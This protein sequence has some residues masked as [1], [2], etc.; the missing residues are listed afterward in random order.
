MFKRWSSRGARA[1]L[2]V[3]MTLGAAGAVPASATV[4]ARR[5][6]KKVNVTLEATPSVTI[7]GTKGQCLITTDGYNI[8]FD[9][10]DYP[11][12][13]ADGELS[14]GG[15][16]PA[17]APDQKRSYTA[18]SATVGGTFYVEDDSNGL[19]AINA[20]VTLNV[21][22]KTIKFTAYPIIAPDTEVRATM[23]GT[24]KCK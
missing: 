7:K 11:S 9:A 15:P 4:G 17:T 14:S 18:F 20:A 12:L 5:S 24:V 19:A 22:R 6:I 8:D 21:K 3:A 16:G 1:A 23:T 13:G 10:K 2:L